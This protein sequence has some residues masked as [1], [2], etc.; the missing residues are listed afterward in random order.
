MF[1]VNSERTCSNL[2]TF[3][4]FSKKSFLPSKKSYYYCHSGE[5]TKPFGSISETRLI[6]KRSDFLSKL[7]I[8]FISTEMLIKMIQI[9]KPVHFLNKWHNW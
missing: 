5:N 3:K 1:T 7:M 6:L 4:H 8:R 9:L 2:S